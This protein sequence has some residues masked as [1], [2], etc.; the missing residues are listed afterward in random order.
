MADA[1]ISGKPLAFRVRAMRRTNALFLACVAG[2]TALQSPVVRADDW[3]CTVLLCLADPR[4]PEAESACV[5]PIEQLW[6]ALRHGDP[7][8]TCDFNSSL[9][10]L[11]ADL[12][13]AIPASAL[14]NLGSGSGAA[15]TPASAGYC[16]EDLLHWGGPEQS[17]LLCNASGAINVTIDGTLFTRVW[18]DAGGQGASI[19][20]YYGTPLAGVP[21]AAP[22]DPAQAAQQFMQLQNANQSGNGGGNH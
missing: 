15:N 18:W 2:A 14:D 11:P 13:N 1:I 10:D 8:P 7:F 19:S 9:N 22:Y 21:V 3:G 6:T 17:E 5:P 20:E 12:R 16:R 4:G